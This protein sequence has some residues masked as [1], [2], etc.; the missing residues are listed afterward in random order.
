[1]I[2]V[3]A[4]RGAAQRVQENTIAAFEE[5]RR[6][7]A[8]GVELDVRRSADGELVIHHDPQLPSGGAISDLP[9]A[10]LPSSI[11]TLDE[12]LDACAGMIVNIEVKNLPIEPGYDPSGA[13]G[14][15][16]AAVA[17]ARGLGERV[18]VSCFDLA[19]LDAV[20]AAHPAIP[21]GWLTLAGYDQHQALD[22]V[23]RRGHP[24]L[25]PQDP[26]VT[27]ELVQAAHAAGVRV[28]A[29]TVND[30][31]RMGELAAMGAD[32]LITDDVALARSVL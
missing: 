16:A 31:H 17:E 6:V 13:L 5:A 28:V 25:H 8:D 2:F 10:A 23:V 12:A 24:F 3:L 32:G 11:P 27:V 7:G 1:M 20:R 9:R 19:T 4:H 22:A 30:A 29:W 15:A 21:T 18:I 26:G 14:L